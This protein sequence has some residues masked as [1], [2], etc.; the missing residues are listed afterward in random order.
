M[1]PKNENLNEII[2]NVGKFLMR[3]IGEDITLTTTLRNDPLTVFA[4]KGQIEQVLM[5]LAT[6]ARDVMHNGGILAIETQIIEID[7][8]FIQSHGYGTPGNFALITVSDNGQGMDEET[9]TNIFEPF[10]TT[11]EV[12]RG[13]GLGL[14]IVYGIVSQHDGYISVHSTPGKGTSFEIYLP[15]VNRQISVK[16]ENRL[17][18]CPAMGSE[19]ILVAED[20]AAVRQLVEQIL[21]KYGYKVILAENGQVAIDAFMANR[22]EIR[23]IYSDLIMPQ[24]SGKELYSEVKAIVPE[25]KFLFTSGYTANMFEKGS[26]LEGT[27]EILR[28]PVAP[29]ELARKI[30]E[31]LDS[32]AS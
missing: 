19:T 10:F 17:F 9:K 26:D 21:N 6:N 14:S 11:K 2:Q 8:L 20:E 30:R 15:L 4:D 18:E 12:G 32:R 31:M 7:D 28:K 27:F 1:Q 16:N 22:D 3:I 13:T 29:V 24:K 5:N 23:L 25:M